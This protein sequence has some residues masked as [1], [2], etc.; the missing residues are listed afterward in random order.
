M[1]NAAGDPIAIAPGD[2]HRVWIDLAQHAAGA[3]VAKVE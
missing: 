1:E 3:F 2:P